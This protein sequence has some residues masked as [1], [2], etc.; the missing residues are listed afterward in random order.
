MRNINILL[1]WSKVCIWLVLIMLVR[2]ITVV[3]GSEELEKLKEVVIEGIK[4]YESSVREVYVEYEVFL[5]SHS[6]TAKVV[7]VE[8]IL[9]TD[10]S[11]HYLQS[12]SLDKER[13]QDRRFEQIWDGERQINVELPSD[14]VVGRLPRRILISPKKELPGLE[15]PLH[16]TPLYFHNDRTL[17]QHIAQAKSSSILN[18]D[19]VWNGR[20]CILFAVDGTIPTNINIYTE[21]VIDTEKGFLPVSITHYKQDKNGNKVKMESFD[22]VK[23]EKSGEIWFPME[24]VRMLWWWTGSSGEVEPPIRRRTVVKNVKINQSILSDK[25]KYEFK[26][27][28]SIF[29]AFIGEGY[30]FG[31]AN[32]GN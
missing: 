14:N 23:V 31:E 22:T 32:V 24:G 20:H 18:S 1:A 13:K 4:F 19:Y 16:Y 5:E 25:L 27:G 29:D 8:E 3:S 9:V 10:G 15:H 28:D 7:S 6:Q 21:I 17:S 12:I 30:F 26:N 11:R 2:G